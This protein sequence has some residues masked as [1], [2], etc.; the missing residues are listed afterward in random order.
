MSLSQLPEELIDEICFKAIKRLCGNSFIVDANSLRD[1]ALTSKKFLPSA[2]RALYYSPFEVIQIHYSRSGSLTLL[3]TLGAGDNRFGRLV[4]TTEGIAHWMT[5]IDS[6]DQELV[7]DSD[8]WYRKILEVC[9]R[10]Q[11][12]E[13]SF[14][15]RDGMKKVFELLPTSIPTLRSLKF[16]SRKE[17]ESELDWKIVLETMRQYPFSSL[18]SVQFITPLWLPENLNASEIPSFPASIRNLA[19]HAG[20]HSMSN[21]KLLFP[22][23]SPTVEVLNFVGMTERDSLELLELPTVLGSNLRYLHLHYGIWAPDV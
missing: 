19:I 15:K 23:A 6:R 17:H 10:L 5:S 13:V 3:H 7:R 2:Q 9:P 16:S 18:D 1:L 8:D 4:R 14:I 22:S 20:Q 21:C 11:E 12:A